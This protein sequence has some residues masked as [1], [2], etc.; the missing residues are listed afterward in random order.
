[1]AIGTDLIWAALWSSAQALPIADHF[2]SYFTIAA[3]AGLS[4]VSWSFIG[5]NTAILQHNSGL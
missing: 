5:A 1:L 2:L 3:G 4:A